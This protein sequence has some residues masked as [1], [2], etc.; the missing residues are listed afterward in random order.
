MIAPKVSFEG[1][2]KQQQPAPIVKKAVSFFNND[3]QQ[4]PAPPQPQAQP[5]A[6]V[7]APAP[8]PTQQAPVPTKQAKQQAKPSQPRTQAHHH[9]DEYIT[10]ELDEMTI[11]IQEY[12]GG[13]AKEKPKRQ[14]SQAQLANLEKMRKSKALKRQQA[15]A[16]QAQAQAQT[17]LLSAPQQSSNTPI[18]NQHDFSTMFKQHF[19]QHY[20]EKEAVRQREKAIRQ[21]AKQKVLSK[22]MAQQKLVAPAPTPAPQPM[23]STV[24]KKL[25]YRMSPFGGGIETYYE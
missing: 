23:E 2:L 13:T 12:L 24:G 18:L 6:P 9:D 11:G 10:T 3:K 21:E 17:P 5:Q 14:S 20:N 1:G 4:A 22:L 16:Q 8:A 7:P 19:E 25:R 15:Q